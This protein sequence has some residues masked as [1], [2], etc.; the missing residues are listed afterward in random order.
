MSPRTAPEPYRSPSL[1]CPRCKTELLDSGLLGH[2]ARCR[3][4]WVPEDVLHD[5]IAVMQQAPPR[6]HWYRVPRA[7][8]PCARCAEPM[9]TLALFDVPIDRCLDHGL[10]FD[11]DE[12]SSVLFRS[13]EAGAPAVPSG[14]GS[15]SESRT[16]H[17]RPVLRPAARAGSG[18]TLHPDLATTTANVAL[19]ITVIDLVAGAGELAEVGFGIGTIIEGIL[20]LLA[21]LFL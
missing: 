15:G 14:P 6:L 20:D 18:T 7:P 9:E 17:F 4:A 8:L 2:C 10:W 1:P 16:L 5:R 13:Q 21:G 3:G 19:D 12:L 11:A